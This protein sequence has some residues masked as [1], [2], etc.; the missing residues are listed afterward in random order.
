MRLTRTSNIQHSKCISPL[1]K[2]CRD[3]DQICFCAGWHFS[4][5]QKSVVINFV[6][7][8]LFILLVLVLLWEWWLFCV[9]V[10]MS[11][12]YFFSL[13][14]VLSVVCVCVFSWFCVQLMNLWLITNSWDLIP[15]DVDDFCLHSKRNWT[16]RQFFLS[17]VLLYTFVQGISIE[18][19][20]FGC[21]WTRFS[22]D[23][24]LH[25]GST[26]FSRARTAQFIRR[27]ECNLSICF[28]HLVWVSCQYNRTWSFMLVNK[29]H[30]CYANSM[31]LLLINQ[32]G[33][34]I[35]KCELNSVSNF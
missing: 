4:R 9:S 6:K 34:D 26:S 30:D 32:L 5:M 35:H 23:C 13:L 16:A 15:F 3:T 21:S 27:I 22:F 10:C 18:S 33:L 19:V 20:G 31:S 7:I 17:F 12:C 14:T 28:C 1:K 24:W 11:S 25:F 2:E 29:T 8:T